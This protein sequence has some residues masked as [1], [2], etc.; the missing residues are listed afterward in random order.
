MSTPNF[1]FF[2]F[3]GGRLH[4]AAART[5][6]GPGQVENRPVV[7]RQAGR[8]SPAHLVYLP[9]VGQVEHRILRPVRQ[10]HRHAPAAPVL[11][12]LR[13][14]NPAIL[15]RRPPS[16]PGLVQQPIQQAGVPREGV[17]LIQQHGL[18]REVHIEHGP[19][20]VGMGRDRRNAPAIPGQHRQRRVHRRH[21]AEPFP[22][23]R[24]LRAVQRDG[25]GF[26][27]V[28][29]ILHPQAG[30]VLKLRQDAAVVGQ[31][32][33]SAGPNPFSVLL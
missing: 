18:R 22:P 19:L 26:R 23:Q 7:R 21:N 3:F 11:R 20:P 13:Q 4:R 2:R 25:I 1:I 5:D 17:G 30:Q 8:I 12:M 31:I 16:L 6:S 15:R 29:G 32:E 28:D 24:Q 33:R 9:A 14:G 27:H 10:V